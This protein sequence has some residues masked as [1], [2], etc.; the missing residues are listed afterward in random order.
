MRKIIAIT[1]AHGFIGQHLVREWQDKENLNARVFVGD[2]TN[3]NDLESFFSKN[4]NIDAVVH[5]A[6][7]FE[8][9]FET[10]WKANVATLWNVVAQ[11][12]QHNI[13][14][15]V[16]LS[17]A[18]VYGGQNS[19]RKK[20][21]DALLPDTEYGLV[22]VMAENVARYAYQQLDVHLPILRLGNVY[23]PGDNGVLARFI[24]Q[25]QNSGEITLFGDGLQ[26]RQFVHVQD[27]VDGIQQII[28][29]KTEFSIFNFAEEKA[30]SMKE[31]ANMLITEY[32]GNIQY[33]PAESQKMK[34]MSLDVSAMQSSLH[35]SPQHDVQKE[36]KA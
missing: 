16:L 27:V 6:G 2:L 13:K 19:N 35:F 33:K 17:S 1:G 8:G 3:T 15:G 32:G 25:L 21:T 24:A 5:L 12:K 7:K 28:E 34:Y 26:T 4:T 9:D 23:G 29:H 10:L 14:Y 20:E 11:M 22:K 31:L 36:C 18:A 30:Y